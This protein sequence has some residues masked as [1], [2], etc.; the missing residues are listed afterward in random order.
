MARW[1]QRFAHLSLRHGVIAG[2]LIITVTAAVLASMGQVLWCACGELWLWS[3]DTLSQHNSQHLTD[4][5]TF[6]HLLHGVLFFYLL[7]GVSKRWPMSLGSRFAIA[8]LLESLW[9]IV[10]NTD[11]V[12]NRYREAT[13]SLNY[14]GDSVVNSVVD[15]AAC[16]VAFLVVAR[17]PWRWTLAGVVVIEVAL[18]LTIRDNLTLNVLM[19][20]Y[21]LESIANWQAGGW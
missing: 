14:Y 15:I 10:E 5:Y 2:V 1:Y 13:I 17:L 8:L 3:G 9:E 12:I 19:L 21:P 11:V 6:T 18:A 20:T 7:W 4:P 16:A